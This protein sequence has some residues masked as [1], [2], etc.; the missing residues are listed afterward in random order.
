MERTKQEWAAFRALPFQKKLEH[1][2][3]YYKWHFVVAA[4]VICLAVSV[5]STVIGSQKEVLVSGMFLNNATSQEG[6]AFLSEDF[7]EACGGG[8]GQKVDL[9]TGRTVDFAAE[10][11]SQ[12]DAASLMVFT[13]MVGAGD[14]D[15]VITDAASVDHLVEQEVLLDLRELLSEQSLAQWDTVEHDGAVTAL[16]LEGTAFAESY[17]LAAEDGC[18]AVLVNAPH[19]ENLLRLLDHIRG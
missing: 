13:C 10:T 11:P 3:I 4:A 6:Y 18:I 17:P 1:L 19:R 14:L 2:W 16:R 5:V 7:R 12:Q 8:S 9:V 15:Y